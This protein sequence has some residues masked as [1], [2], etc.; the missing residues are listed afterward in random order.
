MKRCKEC[1][2]FAEIKGFGMNSCKKNHR[3]ITKS[4]NCGFG[5]E[6]RPKWCPATNQSSK[7]MEQKG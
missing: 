1:E 7:S 2:Y 6:G 3:Y 5:T 4:D